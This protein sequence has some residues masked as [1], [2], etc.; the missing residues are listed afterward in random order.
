MKIKRKKPKLKKVL[1]TCCWCDARIGANQE[2]FTLGGKKNPDMDISRFEGD[3]MPL[4]IESIPKRVWVVVPTEESEARQ[5]GEDFIF[6]I[7]S[8]ECGAELK[9]TLK[10]E[11]EIKKI[12]LSTDFL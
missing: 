3:I 1:H 10:R 6:T 7:C 2:V 11:Q 12:L 5:L 4:L 9:A 8:E